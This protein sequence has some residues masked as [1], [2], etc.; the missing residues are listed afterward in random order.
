MRWR[1]LCTLVTFLIQVILGHCEIMLPRSH[2]PYRL[3]F[4]AYLA[5][6]H[7]RGRARQSPLSLSLRYSTAKSQLAER[8]ACLLH[9]D[10]GDISSRLPPASLLGRSHAVLIRLGLRRIQSLFNLREVR[11]SRC[12]GHHSLCV[13]LNRST[14]I[15]PTPHSLT[16]S[17]KGGKTEDTKSSVD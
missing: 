16:L 17:E 2:V 6:T 11:V 13:E 10:E 12:V 5:R 4:K 8:S 14:P 9:D 3:F 1:C 7:S 15:R